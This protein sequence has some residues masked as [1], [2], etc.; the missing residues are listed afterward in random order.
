MFKRAQTHSIDSTVEEERGPEAM[1]FLRR[2]DLGKTCSPCFNIQRE[3]ACSVTKLGKCLGKLS[4]VMSK[5]RLSCLGGSSLSH[6]LQGLSLSRPSTG[7]RVKRD[8]TVCAGTLQQVF[9]VVRLCFCW[10][11]SSLCHNPS[12][13]ASSGHSA[14]NSAKLFSDGSIFAL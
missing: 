1:S 9:L 8:F 11:L 12:L 14:A 4:N 2:D 3:W 7:I 5:N 13:A 10:A 6:R